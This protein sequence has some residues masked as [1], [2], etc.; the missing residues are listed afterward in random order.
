V[1]GLGLAVWLAVFCTRRLVAGVQVYGEHVRGVDELLQQREVRPAPASPHQL[2]RE[3]D[4]EVVERLAGVFAVGDPG[5]GLPVVADLPSLGHHALGRA[6]L[7][8]HLG[9]QTP[10]EG[11]GADVVGG[12]Y[13]IGVHLLPIASTVLPP[14]FYPHRGLRCP[15][16]VTAT[17]RSGVV[18]DASVFRRRPR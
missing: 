15:Q 3:L 13:R 2:I 16:V 14:V 4:D 17:S 6:P 10:P 12:L 5:R 8:E 11:V 1:P 7:T 18:V 9:D